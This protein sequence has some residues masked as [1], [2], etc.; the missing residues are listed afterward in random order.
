MSCSL[1]LSL[2][3][4]YTIRAVRIKKISK[5][6]T[7][8]FKQS[9]N[10]RISRT[11]RGLERSCRPVPLWRMF[12]MLHTASYPQQFWSKYCEQ[13]A[14]FFLPLKL[15]FFNGQLVFRVTLLS[16]SFFWEYKSAGF[17][18]VCFWLAWKLVCISSQRQEGNDITS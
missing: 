14:V 9:Q 18:F 12:I 13:N 6:K 17:L 16:N 10:Q 2:I 3:L 4:C 7:P 11:G 15:A 8:Y 5:K 1:L